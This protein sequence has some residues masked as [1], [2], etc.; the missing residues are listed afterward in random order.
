M[1]TTHYTIGCPPSRPQ[2]SRAAGPGERIPISDLVSFALDRQ[3]LHDQNKPLFVDA[4]DP[5]LSL[6]AS[7]TIALV[8]GLV[9]G[10]RAAGLKKGHA[11]FSHP[12][13][14]PSIVF[15]PPLVRCSFCP[16][17]CSAS[18][19]TK[20][21][22]MVADVPPFFPFSSGIYISKQNIDPPTLAP[23]SGFLSRPKTAVLPQL[24]SSFPPDCGL[25]AA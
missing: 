16:P 11:V 24:C 4:H 3:H 9:A 12:G 1:Y 13:N 15:G 19:P 7:Q 21:A 25:H 10:L 23:L 20:I 18:E 22:A 5:I 2:P 17:L 6:S 14:H 8:F